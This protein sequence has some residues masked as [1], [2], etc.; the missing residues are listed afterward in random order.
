MA[1]ARALAKG[2]L[3]SGKAVLYTID[4]PCDVARAQILQRN[5]KAIGLELEIKQFPVTLYFDKIGTP[6]EP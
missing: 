3:R 6:G 2:N 4:H 1:K 5:L